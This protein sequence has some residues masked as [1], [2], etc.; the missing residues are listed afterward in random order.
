MPT[1][2]QELQTNIDG[3][4][5]H[6]P[7]NNSYQQR[8][9]I[10]QKVAAEIGNGKSYEDFLLE[11][12]Q[13]TY[14]ILDN[15]MVALI[16]DFLFFK[17]KTDM[18]QKEFYLEQYHELLGIATS[19]DIS[20]ETVQNFV[21]RL[22]TKRPLVFWCPG[23]N[24]VDR[25]GVSEELQLTE[26]SNE[27]VDPKKRVNPSEDYISY[28]EMQISAFLQV[29][30]PSLFLNDGSRYNLGKESQKKTFVHQGI[31]VG[32][33]GARFENQYMETTFMLIDSEQ[34]VPGNG[35]GNQGD[36]IAKNR[37]THWAK[38][39]GLDHFPSYE[40]AKATYEQENPAGSQPKQ[41]QSYIQLP[42]NQYL[43]VAVYK[44]RMRKV[45]EAFLIEANSRATKDKPA[46]V[47]AVGLGVGAWA[48]PGAQLQQEKLLLEVYADILKEMEFANIADI[49]FAYFNTTEFNGKTNQVNKGNK[50]D[51]Y[52]HLCANTLE[53]T[54]NSQI[55]I[56]LSNN[57]PSGYGANKTSKYMQNKTLVV[58]Y[59]WDSGSFPGNEFWVGHLSASGDP[60]TNCSTQTAELQNPLINPEFTTKC[61]IAKDSKL[62]E[63]SDSNEVE[64]PTLEI[65]INKV[66]PL[67][68]QK[69]PIDE[70]GQ[71]LSLFGA[72]G[73][74]DTNKLNIYFQQ[75]SEKFLV[76]D[77]RKFFYKVKNKEKKPNNSFIGSI[78][79][80][81]TT[82]AE[83]SPT[84]I[85]KT[86]NHKN[87][88][89]LKFPTQLKDGA[90]DGIQKD[91]IVDFLKDFNIALGK[92]YT[93]VANG[94]QPNDL[95][96]IL[97]KI[98]MINKEP[99]GEKILL[100]FKLK[101]S[102]KDY[103]LIKENIEIHNRNIEAIKQSTTTPSSVKLEELKQ[104]SIDTKAPTT[105]LDG[106]SHGH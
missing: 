102:G 13:N 80:I 7:T 71:K 11:N 29:S 72:T 60:S 78:Q 42:G 94:F 17:A 85:V 35:Y 69:S 37:L 16:K 14:P 83:K 5:E 105:H 46:Y 73:E 52:D 101:D 70:I 84:T 50:T 21:S 26:N 28:D 96:D 59:A 20:I 63:L 87:K 57:N 86:F 9:S 66:D 19:D 4:T 3:F 41:P 99:N 10:F 6:Y 44:A 58:Q 22:L 61:M 39:Y 38:F 67:N 106:A 89:T 93:A 90:I 65:P 97:N 45:I 15:S 54:C 91:W 98:H 95:M 100:K 18:A 32:S 53:G 74:F 48:I 81:G 49:D 34:N 2:L 8:L 30:S 33:V 25:P 82:Q 51:K 92:K 1:T 12:A 77:D 76:A 27:V 43:N 104:L 40:E 75:L 64:E 23:D 55:K 36:P 88:I 31:I 47:H 62:Q 103:E 79:Y 56:H 24:T 68:P